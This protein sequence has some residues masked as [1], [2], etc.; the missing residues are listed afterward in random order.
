MRANYCE[1]LLR[2]FYVEQKT[3][4]AVI[5]VIKDLSD[6]PRSAAATQTR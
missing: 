3:L 2:E 1:R 5:A 4:I 6:T